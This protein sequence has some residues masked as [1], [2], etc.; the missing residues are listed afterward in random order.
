VFDKENNMP[1]PSAGQAVMQ[2][3]EKAA[4]NK[5]L[6]TMFW[7][8]F[9]IMLGGWALVPEETIPE[10]AWSIG[11]GLLMLGLNVTRYFLGIRMSGFTTIVGI[12]L[13]LGVI[14]GNFLGWK[15]FNGAFLLILLGL[16][17]VLKPWFDKYKLFGKAEKS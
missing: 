13:V 11:V 12:L 3:S 5:Q 10:G 4:L 6:E 8:L 7:G 16:Y 1:T 2:D 14:C 15:N 17:L 9:L